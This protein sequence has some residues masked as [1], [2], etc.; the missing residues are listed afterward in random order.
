MNTALEKVKELLE[1]QL[2][3]CQFD[4]E[5]CR[6]EK[7]ERQQRVSED[8]ACNDFTESAVK[9]LLTTVRDVR[10]LERK[11][12]FLTYILNYVKYVATQ[13]GENA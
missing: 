13:E 1:R 6:R 11:E 4:L 5:S 12:T 8:V 2:Y 3:A 7:D 10:E 9:A